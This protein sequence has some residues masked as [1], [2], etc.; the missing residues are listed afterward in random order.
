MFVLA[1]ATFYGWMLTRLRIPQAILE[2]LVLVTKNPYLIITLMILF[3][4]RL[5]LGR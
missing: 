3:V 5:F 4:P 1:T 2:H